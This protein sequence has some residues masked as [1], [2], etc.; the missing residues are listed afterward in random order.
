[1]EVEVEE[2]NAVASRLVSGHRADPNG[3]I[4]TQ[5]QRVLVARG[6]HPDPLGGLA[7]D[8]H[9]LGQVLGSG[10]LPVGAPAPDLA[11]AVVVH[12]RPGI[13]EQVEQAG[14][15][16]GRRSELLAGGEGGGARRHADDSH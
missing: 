5:D 7:D 3:A 2:A 16:Q 4:P 13:A 9:D 11:I 6:S 8:R 10:M 12:V 15:A 1:V 14:G